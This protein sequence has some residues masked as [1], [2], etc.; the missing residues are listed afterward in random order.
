MCHWQNIVS[1]YKVAIGHEDPQIKVP[2]D[3]LGSLLLIVLCI[4]NLMHPTPSESNSV[5]GSA[6]T[7]YIYN[8]WGLT[9]ILKKDSQLSRCNIHMTLCRF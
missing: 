6:N 4:S 7:I 1:E 8:L 9:S 2:S 5:H 3:S